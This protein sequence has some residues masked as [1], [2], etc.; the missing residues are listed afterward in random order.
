MD[1]IKKKYPFWKRLLHKWQSRRDI[2]FRKK[3][4]IGYDLYGNTYWEF[5]IDGN[6]SRLRRKLEPFRKEL[7]EVDYF[8]TIPPQ[9]LQWLRRTREHSPSL[10]ELIEDQIRQQRIKILAQQ[11]DENWKLEKLRL[12]RE[13]QLKL[14]N[15]LNKVK[16]ENEKFIEKQKRKEK[17]ALLRVEDPWKQAEE[18]KNENPIESTT[19][20][21]RS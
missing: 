16:L 13:Q 7:F 14:S 10:N 1:I 8:K 12:E 20:K 5:T 18:S 19:I 17:E 3:F 9:W 2:P 15:E 11:A 4:F 21:P 6:M